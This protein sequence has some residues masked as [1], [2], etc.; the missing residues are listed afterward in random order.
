[1]H[2][3]YFFGVLGKA[4]TYTLGKENQHLVSQEGKGEPHSNDF[5]TGFQNFYGGKCCY[6]LAII[7][8]VMV[9][10]ITS[11][12]NPRVALGR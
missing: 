3:I 9:A 10:E 6:I 2:D 8:K 1:M 4:Q 12:N 7:L 11:E 5:T